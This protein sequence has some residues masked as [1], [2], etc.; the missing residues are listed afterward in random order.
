[1]T[2]PA[3]DTGST[4]RPM[5][6]ADVEAV[7]A[8]EQQSFST[9][10]DEATFVEMLA[11]TGRSKAWVLEA[12]P[13]PGAEPEVVGYA[14]LRFVQEEGELVNIAIREDLRGQ[15]RGSQLLDGVVGRAREMGLK[16]LFLEVR[17]SNVRA[18][19]MYQARG[20]LVVGIR[21]AYYT[22]PVEDAKIMLLTLEAT[23]KEEA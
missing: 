1:M 5:E 9:P 12:E 21:R 17:R 10:W 8:I 16:R 14:I 13:E 11:W 19:E 7:A 22:R 6:A 23:N 3:T 4:I 20:F 18:L 2:T 15:H